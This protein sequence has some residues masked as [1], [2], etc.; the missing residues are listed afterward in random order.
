MLS[1]VRLLRLPSSGRNNLNR[2]LFNLCA[3]TAQRAALL[4]MLLALLR[5]PLSA[6]E[7]DATGAPSPLSTACTTPATLA[8]AMAARV[9]AGASG[10]VGPVLALGMGRQHEGQALAPVVTRRVLETLAYLCRCVAPPPAC[11][12]TAHSADAWPAKPCGA[13][14]VLSLAPPAPA[15]PSPSFCLC[16]GTTA[17]CLGPW[18]SSGCLPWSSWRTAWPRSSPTL[19]VRHR[20][21]ASCCSCSPV[22]QRRML[23]PPLTCRPGTALVLLPYSGKGKRKVDDDGGVSASAASRRGL[24][25]LLELPARHICRRSDTHMHSTLEVRS[26]A[27]LGVDHC[28][29]GCGALSTGGSAPSL[30][31]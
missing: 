24:Y 16:A 9:P 19:R 7:A 5:G 13:A 29:A 12:A 23:P 14:M 17:R 22:E 18:W 28:S 11:V 6:D 3:N 1:L 26:A 31:S 10:A 15:D 27:A 4:S 30:A 25:V 20:T 21:S 8:E 2:L